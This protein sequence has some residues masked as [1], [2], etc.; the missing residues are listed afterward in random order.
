MG[1]IYELFKL[2]EKD[3]KKMYYEMCGHR[4]LQK[5]TSGKLKIQDGV[6]QSK[7]DK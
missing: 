5:E 1:V 2:P 7:S 6:L 4:T 3:R